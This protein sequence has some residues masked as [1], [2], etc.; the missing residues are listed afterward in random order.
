MRRQS[1][2][3]STSKQELEVCKHW[4]ALP[5]KAALTSQRWTWM[6]TEI[7]LRKQRSP[8]SAKSSRFEFFWLTLDDNL[9]W[10]S[11]LLQ[12]FFGWGPRRLNPRSSPPTPL[13]SDSAFSLGCCQK[14]SRALNIQTMKQKKRR[15]SSDADSC[16]RWGNSRWKSDGRTLPLFARVQPRGKPL[17]TGN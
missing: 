9:H 7:N 1:L 11:I 16:S 12:A 15:I 17:W 14:S 10:L 13:K 2:S 6:D 4:F 8:L 3:H 5:L